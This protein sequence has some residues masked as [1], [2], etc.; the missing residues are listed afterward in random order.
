MILG[1]LGGPHVI[2]VSRRGWLE[3]WSKERQGLRRHDASGTEDGG[4]H[5][6]R[7]TA[8]SPQEMGKARPCVS[9]ELPEGG[10]LCPQCDFN[11]MRLILDF[12]PKEL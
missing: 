4:R 5:L 1:Y 3:G 12:W 8:E 6:E 2:M 11:P 7:R 9:P 10:Q